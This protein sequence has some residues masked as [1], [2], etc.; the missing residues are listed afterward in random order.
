MWSLA[1]LCF[2]KLQVSLSIYE[3]YSIGCVAMVTRSQ[4]AR[5]DNGEG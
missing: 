5:A 1:K 3:A 4:I 2:V